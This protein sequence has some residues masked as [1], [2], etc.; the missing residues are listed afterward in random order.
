LSAN[1]LPG[2]LSSFYR[3]LEGQGNLESNARLAL[4]PYTDLRNIA[5]ALKDAQPAAEGAAPH[6]VDYAENLA[7]ALGE[8]I[9][10]RF[11]KSF[12]DTMEKIK[13]PSKELATTDELMR[14]W[15]EG[16]ELLLD[17]QEP[18]EVS[19]VLWGLEEKIANCILPR[20]LLSQYGAR[21][22]PSKARDPPVLLPLELMAHP[23]ELRFKYHFS[24]NKVTNRLEKV[25]NCAIQCLEN[26]LICYVLGV[27]GIL[28][29]PCG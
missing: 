6:L 24:G 3:S 2:H 1:L 12:Q 17:L 22:E 28:P 15:R 7:T 23:L 9:K 11:G 29:V 14:E 19:F 26:R 8:H 16:V 21:Q 27:A 13:W 5:S 20:E 4:R 10:K 18:Y 25:F